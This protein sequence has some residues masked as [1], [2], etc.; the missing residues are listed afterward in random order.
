MTNEELQKISKIY[1]KENSINPKEL[2]IWA[3]NSYIESRR[4]GEVATLV[5]QHDYIPD[6]W[7]VE[8]KDGTEGIYSK[9][10]LAKKV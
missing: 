3:S 6:L 2:A 10:E 7:I 9:D 5:C 4:K 8:H 1:I